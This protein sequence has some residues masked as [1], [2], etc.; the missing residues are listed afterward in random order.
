LLGVGAASSI[1]RRITG[2]VAGDSICDSDSFAVHS[3]SHIHSSATHS[4]PHIHLDSH[5]HHPHT[6]AAAR[7]LHKESN[8]AD[9]MPLS[10]AAR[11]PLLRSFGVGLI[12]GL[13]GSAA[14]ALLALTAIPQPLWA[15]FYLTIF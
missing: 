10:F 7:S 9:D 5:D 2:H 11:C 4:H 8:L 13:A 12:H 15:T 3:H 14:I 1:L 6:D